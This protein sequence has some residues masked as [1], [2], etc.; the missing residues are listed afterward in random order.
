M[1]VDGISSFAAVD[2]GASSGRVVAGRVGPDTLELTE[3][4]RF[5]NE[6]VR[7]AGTLHWNVTGLYAEIL[8]GLRFL[9]RDH[10]VP[11][12]IGVD[13]WAVDY[14]LLDAEGALL[15]AP[16]HYRDE[17]TEGVAAAVAAEIGAASL[18]RRTGLQT[19]PFNTV[20][21]LVAGRKSAAYQA[22][23]ALLLIPDLIGYWLT[24]AQG[25]EVTN[26]STTQLL[27]VHRRSW[28]VELA[29]D[30][31]LR[32]EL[33]P[34]LRQPG[35]RL[36]GLR[37]DV[38]AEVGFDA[39][40]VAVASH[41]TA[42]AVIGVP[43]VGDR[44][45]YISCGT[46][47]LAG[48]ELD[49]PVLSEAS[50][51]ANF[52][53]EAGIDGTVRYLRNVMGLWLLQESVRW[54]ERSGSGS[55]LPTLLA[56]A[57]EVPAGRTVIDVDDAR[58]LPPGDMPSRIAAFARETGQPVPATRGEVVRCI[59]DSLALAFR[60][61]IHQASSL[62]S[63]DVD[64][65]H[66]VGGGARNALLCRLTAD[67]TGLPVVAGPVEATALGNVLVQARAAGVV[68][69]L[70]E[71][72]ALLAATQPTVRYDPRPGIDWDTLAARL[73]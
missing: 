26:A 13:S 3:A 11:R 7:L 4:H 67:A 6:P 49:R 5:V 21:Q 54:W 68:G 24:G 53:N 12:S 63:H 40:V 36:G 25:A 8:R 44:F 23:G 73:A 59:L 46:W 48:L 29:T 35:D 72:R 61:T 17:R 14:G 1:N 71:A 64:V 28:D 60:R 70:G 56:D 27:D 31:R 15:G 2:L 45:A 65:V 41:D 9:G 58:F 47:G 20:Y 22:A 69:D 30:L 18:Y 50:R 62:A 33:L 39:P 55:D 10:A 38:A 66:L 37:E 57:A 32:P 34:P 51:E 16:V 42:S 19:L 43:A 52:T